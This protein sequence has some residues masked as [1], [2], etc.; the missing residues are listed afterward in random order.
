MAAEI[1][2]CAERQHWKIASYNAFSETRF[3]AA[4]SISKNL[5]PLF[6]KQSMTVH[7]QHVDK[8]DIRDCAFEQAAN[9]PQAS[10]A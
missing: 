6:V 10:K 2:R 5:T 1:Q 7:T 4:M 9:S 8:S 3:G